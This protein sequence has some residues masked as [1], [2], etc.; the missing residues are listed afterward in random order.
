MTTRR[1]VGDVVGRMFHD[2]VVWDDVRVPGSMTRAAAANNPTVALFRDNGA[3]SVGVWG[4]SFANGSRR[5]V[6]FDIQFPHS[7]ALGL[8]VVPHVHWATASNAVGTVTW[9]F[10][11]TWA[12][13]GATIPVTQILTQT[14]TIPVGGEQYKHQLTSFGDVSARDATLTPFGI[15][16]MMMCR[17]ARRGDTD[18]HAQPVFLLEF[19]IHY[20]M[21]LLGSLGPTSKY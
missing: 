6:F 19:D 16:S 21:D 3:G 20:P 5:E 7:M 18:T 15:S 10:E 13:I 2:P 9:D 14:Y 12:S 8:T 4:L 17:L 11:Y 1:I